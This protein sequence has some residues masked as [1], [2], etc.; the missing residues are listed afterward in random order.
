MLCMQDY[1][2]TFR[3]WACERMDLYMCIYTYTY[4]G[5][6]THVSFNILSIGNLWVYAAPE[7]VMIGESI[8]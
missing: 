7:Y 2:E 8:V 1:N 3:F 5:D 4:M 6:Q